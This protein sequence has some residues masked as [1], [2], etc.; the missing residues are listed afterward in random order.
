MCRI[1]WV[2]IGLFVIIGQSSAQDIGIETSITP[3]NPWIY[4]EM[5]YSVRVISPN[6]LENLQIEL[7]TLTYIGQ[8]GDTSFVQSNEV[9]DGVSSFV[10]T[11]TL[12]LAPLQSGVLDI[13]SVEVR[14]P[15]SPFAPEQLLIS[16]ALSFDV[17]AL[18]DD[19]P[20]S[21]ANAIGQF[22]IESSSIATQIDTSENINWSVTIRGQGNFTVMSAPDVTGDSWRILDRGQSIADVS[23]LVREVT[24]EYTLIPRETGILTLPQAT[25]AYFNPIEGRYIT[26][27]TSDQTI[28]ILGTLPESVVDDGNNQR[29]VERFVVNQPLVLDNGIFIFLWVF[30]LLVASI[31]FFILRFGGIGVTS[32]RSKS[33]RIKMVRMRSVL[34]NAQVMN[35]QDAFRTI[36]DGWRAFL[37][38]Q[39]NATDDAIAKTLYPTKI[40]RMIRVC[41]NEA[42]DGQYAPVDAEQVTQLIRKCTATLDAIE[43]LDT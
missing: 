31:V 2:I 28:E 8:Y 35:G 18:P 39:E 33:R 12:Q 17:R 19:A 11:Q 23:E 5:V 6:A 41:V 32:T 37:G 1:F 9:I 26:L 15:E 25:F 43:R 27:E 30:P 14:V 16:D 29:V 4:S 38:I 10:Y 13:P 36:L 3:K 24:Y 22:E 20:S 34:A 42:R 21:F 7:P 40:K